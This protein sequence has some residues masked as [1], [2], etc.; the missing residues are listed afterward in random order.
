MAIGSSG[1]HARPGSPQRGVQ[2][3]IG[4]GVEHVGEP[5]A[6]GV[7][8]VGVHD[9]ATQPREALYLERARL[10]V[11]EAG[12]HLAQDLEAVRGAEMVGEQQRRRIRLGQDV[13]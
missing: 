7:G 10:G 8:I 13:R 11:R 4:A 9:D 1:A 5:E 3:G 6:A 2:R 12:Q